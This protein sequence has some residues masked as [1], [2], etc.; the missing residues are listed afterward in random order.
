MSNASVP[1]LAGVHHVKLPVRELGRSRDWYASRLGFELAVEFV[2]GGRLMGYV[3]RHPRGGPHLGLRLDPAR[4]EAAAGFDYFAIGVRDKAALDTLAARLTEL[5]ETH[6][7]V[8]R[9]SAGWVL[10][11]L[12]DPDGHEIRFYT[13]DLH[14]ELGTDGVTTIHDPRES[15]ERQEQGSPAHLP[16]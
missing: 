10:P 6:A 8:H 12:H 13:V 9:A 15:A 7:G 5:G 14:T 2:E 3:L 4:A 16:L 1:E 11:L